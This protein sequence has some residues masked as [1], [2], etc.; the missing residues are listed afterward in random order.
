LE[1]EE[2]EFILSQAMQPLP[3]ARKSVVD[4]LKATL[5]QQLHSARFSCLGVLVNDSDF[6]FWLDSASVRSGNWIAAPPQC[7]PAHATVVVAFCSTGLLSGVSAALR[8][9]SSASSHASDGSSGAAVD[10]DDDVDDDVATLRADNADEP[11]QLDFTWNK[12]YF[13]LSSYTATATHQLLLLSGAQSLQDCHSEFTYAVRGLASLTT[14]TT[15]TPS[16]TATTTATTSVTATAS[17]TQSTSSSAATTSSTALSSSPLAAASATSRRLPPLMRNMHD[18]I[19]QLS[20]AVS[21]AALQA[22]VATRMIALDDAV[23]RATFRFFVPQVRSLFLVRCVQFESRNNLRRSATLCSAFTVPTSSSPCLSSAPPTLT[24]ASWRNIAFKSAPLDP[25]ALVL[26][27]R[28]VCVCVCVCVLLFFVFACLRRS[29]RSTTTTR[30]IATRRSVCSTT[31]KWRPSTRRRR[32]VGVSLSVCADD[33]SMTSA[34]TVCRCRQSSTSSGRRATMSSS[35]VLPETSSP[36][37]T[38]STSAMMLTSSAP[39]AL[40]TPPTRRRAATSADATTTAAAHALRP[41][42]RLRRAQLQLE[43]N[44]ALGAVSAALLELSTPTTTATTATT[45]AATPTTTATMATNSA[46]TSLA[47][48]GSTESDAAASSSSSATPPLPPT[49]AALTS[50]SIMTART[51][52]LRQLLQRRVAPLIAQSA[53]TTTTTT[54]T[55]KSE[56]QKKATS[57]LD[58]DSDSDSASDESDSEE[59]DEDDDGSDDVDGSSGSSGGDADV[60]VDENDADDA[61]VRQQL[62][63]RLGGDAD[64]DAMA[65]MLLA[66]PTKRRLRAVRLCASEVMQLSSS[67]HLLCSPSSQ[68][69]V[70]PSRSRAPFMLFVECIDGNERKK[71][72]SRSC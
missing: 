26:N 7:L 38:S 21:D 68:A 42:R 14:P 70:L 17:P 27:C 3:A 9:N 53:T 10:D 62:S 16:T 34:S 11:V 35:G 1:R 36:L 6:E 71:S 40:T 15:T 33:I 67:S 57:M 8:Y 66:L 5:Y 25:I 60:D 55:S 44:A 29:R 31:A 41:L 4:D 30:G 48:N 39:P 23:S 52:L 58:S 13:G 63:V 64:A 65:A 20:L 54:T 37:L 2:V 69:F 45:P 43:F 50:T 19:E 22:I 49:T 28:R 12:P 24:R 59:E 61:R 56:T 18:V 32:F 46:T 51:A 47:E 72:R